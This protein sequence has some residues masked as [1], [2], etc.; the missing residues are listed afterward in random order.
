MLS[1]FYFP[2]PFLHIQIRLNKIM[3]QSVRITT[4]VCQFEPRSWR[5]VLDKADGHDL[6]EILLKM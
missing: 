1:I 4:Y 5:G 3:L 2:L 6:T